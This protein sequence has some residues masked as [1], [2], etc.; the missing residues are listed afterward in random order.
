[1]H[2]SCQGY[3]LLFVTDVSEG[4]HGPGKT[5]PQL[6]TSSQL[7]PVKQVRDDAARLSR[8][9][10]SSSDRSVRRRQKRAR[11]TKRTKLWVLTRGMGQRFGWLSSKAEAETLNDRHKSRDGGWSS[12]PQV[13]RAF[14]LDDG[15]REFQ[16]RR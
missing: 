2:K 8:V 10:N 7:A 5:R 3:I 14:E 6:W 1:M 9:F 11:A 16:A 4:Q 15:G 13:D 12:V